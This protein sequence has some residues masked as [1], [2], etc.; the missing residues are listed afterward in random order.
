MRSAT[1][2]VRGIVLRRQTLDGWFA[3]PR[4]YRSPAVGLA[5]AP[6]DRALAA[7]RSASADCR[8]RI[9]AARRGKRDFA[10]ARPVSASFDGREASPLAVAVNRR[11]EGLVGWSEQTPDLRGVT[12][13]ARMARSGAPA[14]AQAIAPAGGQPAVALTADGRA[15]V[16]V[17]SEVPP[18]KPS[19]C[20]TV[21]DVRLA[22]AARGEPFAAPVAVSAA[23]P[24]GA[25]RPVLAAIGDDRVAVVWQRYSTHENDR[26]T[27]CDVTY[28][29][30]G[31][32]V[33]SP[34]GV[35][36]VTPVGGGELAAFGWTAGRALGVWID[37]GSLRAGR[38]FP[39][40]QPAP[41]STR[42]AR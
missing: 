18:G 34:S 28:R 27:G 8:V 1:V 14:A 32:A 2:D 38:L 11:G 35:E 16:A 33:A 31:A 25:D 6:G 26:G 20:G 39:R 5:V 24:F 3:G 37:R 30:P 13:A 42:P 9:V 29:G 10:R 22:A 15:Y 12:M 4:C 17:A 36:E 41:A 40:A 21:A 7:W 23:D 19:Q